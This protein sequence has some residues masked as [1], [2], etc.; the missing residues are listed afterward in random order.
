M[1]EQGNLNYP[2]LSNSLFALNEKIS[3]IVIINIFGEVINQ[4]NKNSNIHEVSKET[5]DQFHNIAFATSILTFENIKFM[6]LEKQDLKII[7][8]NLNHDSI[9]IG[10]DK[11]ADWLDISD[12]FSYLANLMASINSPFSV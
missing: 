3:Y 2:H 10:I 12:I 4:Y 5:S 6:L 7:I 8:I 1:Q 11:K 9:I